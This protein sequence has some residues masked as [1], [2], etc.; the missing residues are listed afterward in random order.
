MTRNKFVKDFMDLVK[1]VARLNNKCL[2]QGHSSLEGEVEDLNHENI[3]RGLYLIID[4]ADASIIDEIYTNKISF[5]KDKYERQFL[6]II[7]RSLLGI[8]KKEDTRFLYF[9][10]CSLA[11]LS[12]DEQNTIDSIVL[13]D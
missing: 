11:N 13:R 7:K 6:T 9:A 1:N 10:L 2:K 5:V 3:K 8:K 4:G 12:K